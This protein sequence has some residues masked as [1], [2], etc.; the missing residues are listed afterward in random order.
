MVQT[1][2]T[3]PWWLVLLMFLVPG[4]AGTGWALLMAPVWRGHGLPGDLALD[5][6]PV[7]LVG[8][9]GLLLALGWRR[10]GRLSL[11][12]V[13]GF[14][15]RTPWPRLVAV[16][17]GLFAAMVALYVLLL[18]VTG[19]VDGWFPDLLGDEPE[20]TLSPAGLTIYLVGV[21]VCNGIAEPIVEELYFR[22][23]LLPRMPVAGT[24]A[25][26]VNAALFALQHFWQP[27]AF[28]FVFVAQVLLMVVM[29]RLDDLRVSMIGHCLVNL[30]G[31]AMTIAAV[32]GG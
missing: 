10:N 21:V 3:Y 25:I 30:T 26:L 12:G 4:A 18:P 5:L 29:T 19:L 15:R 32:T 7:I 28:L 24:A 27:E 31:A 6:S 13:V 11:R 16:C 17:A 9:L 20:L 22:G 1:R 14:R 23:H 8:E 2:K